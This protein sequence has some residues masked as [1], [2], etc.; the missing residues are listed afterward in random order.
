MKGYTWNQG[1]RTDRLVLQRY[2]T[3][4]H[5]WWSVSSQAVDNGSYRFGSERTYAAGTVHL[6][7]ILLRAGRWADVARIAVTVRART[8]DTDPSTTSCPK[9]A[10]LHQQRTVTTPNCPVLQ[11]TTHDEQRTVDWR[12]DTAT[13]S[14]VQD[15]GPWTVVAGS[16]GTRAAGAA[17]CVKLTKCGAGDSAA[18][19]GTC[20]LGTSRC[21]GLSDCTQ[22]RQIVRMGILRE[23]VK[24]PP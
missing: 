12:W 24:P 6:R 1:R 17:D 19:G 4:K 15:P 11:V 14:W 10:L 2:S 5:R 23:D 7:T 21:R 18:T 20:S 9:P 16:T 3:A 22:N 13:T 8:C